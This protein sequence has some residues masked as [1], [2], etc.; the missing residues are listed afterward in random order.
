MKRSI[1]DH[2]YRPDIDGL[3]AVAV[4]PVV[5][6]HLDLSFAPGG[7]V[8]VDV[9]FVI[10]GYLITSIIA[11]EIDGDVF[12]LARFY[13]RRI[14]RIFPALFVMIAAVLAL[15]P[16][17]FM[18][19]DLAEAAQSA[20]AATLFASN[21]LFFWEAGY[22]DAAAYGKP[23][24]HTWSLAIEEQFYIVTPLLLMALAR[25][26]GGDGFVRRASLWILALT[27]F[28][29]ALSILTT[30]AAPTA[31]YYL[32]PWRAWELGL[33]AL[34]ALGLGPRL[35]HPALR[36][37]A[38]ALGLL[39]ILAA[40]V[41][42]D[43][44]TPF[45]GAAALAPTVGAAL[46]I[47]AGRFGPSI[48]GQALGA[49]PLVW[50][51]KL[52]YSLYLWHWP[53]IVGFVYWRMD[54]PNEAAAAGLF[55][56]S[57]FLA[58]ISLR[59]VETPFRRPGWYCARRGVFLGAGAA[60]AVLFM[61]GAGLWLLKGLP[62]RLPE[63]AR[64]LAAASTDRDPRMREC[65]HEKKTPADW[66]DP[67]VYGAETD[68]PPRIAL[69]GD[70]H[71]SALIPALLGRGEGVALYSKF[72]CPPL[73]DFEW[74]LRDYELC[75]E[76][77]KASRAA[78]LSDPDLD[79]V[80]LAARTALFAKGWYDDVGFGERGRAP[81]VI[82]PAAAPLPEGADRTAFMISGLEETI[83]ALS[84]AGKSVALAYPVPEVGNDVPL[85]LSR[86]AMR[87]G[88]P[89]TLT[90]PRAEF[91]RRNARIVAEYDRL[92]AEHG[93]TPI[94]LHETI[95]DAQGCRLYADGA[96]LYYDKNHLSVAGARW[97]APLFNVVFAKSDR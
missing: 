59:F 89:E 34:L 2:E 83:R 16:L 81:V 23:L 65:V 62:E 44:S 53:V 80:V 28:S 68:A 86:H 30:T 27:A 3:R 58:W 45:P 70:S 41:L 79:V 6:F 22:F 46:I 49:S 77:L 63:E 36:Q 20:A 88:A 29:L 93:V 37:G 13:E 18:P 94:R 60:M 14:R 72:G 67:C 5:A 55:A 40:I 90:T 33:G 85:S 47:Q 76:F 84:A 25:F 24:L 12:S 19:V 17:V 52:S 11:R 43:K 74:R 97:L 87:G 82:G 21:F 39:M 32:L 92:V 78:I 57:L 4:L 54:L 75:P 10:S 42:I 61:A 64:R 96:A 50:I 91:E 9:F 73:P 8:G 71:A 95:C 35:T 1:A 26:G 56:L 38:A 69:W 7:F 31:A 51:G 48:A 66:A 15:A